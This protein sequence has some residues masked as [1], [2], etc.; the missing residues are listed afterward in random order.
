MLGQARKPLPT[1]LNKQGT[2]LLG[3]LLA[4]LSVVAT[5]GKQCKLAGNRSSHHTE[6]CHRS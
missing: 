2:R 1:K 5:A 6:A 4:Q 3:Q